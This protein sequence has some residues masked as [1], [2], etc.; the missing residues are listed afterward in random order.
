MYDDK[1]LVSFGQYLLSEEREHRLKC[2]LLSGE[3]LTVF[4]KNGMVSTLDGKF[5]NVFYDDLKNW[6]E[7]REHDKSVTTK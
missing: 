4:G 5:K 6:K 1:D 7:Q 3:G 2:H